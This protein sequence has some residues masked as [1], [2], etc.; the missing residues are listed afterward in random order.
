MWLPW[1]VQEAKASSMAIKFPN[2]SRHYEATRHAVRFWGHDRSMESTFL[3]TVEAL[4]RIQPNLRL[5]AAD[6]LRAFD[7]NRERI[8]AMAARAY[9]RGRRSSYEL[10]VVDV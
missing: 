10:N 3:V 7:V 8:Y 6:I 1:K 2:Q 5:D 4:R 9:A